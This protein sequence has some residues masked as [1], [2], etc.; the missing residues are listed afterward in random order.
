MPSG[1]EC[2]LHEVE[3]R[4]SR[5]RLHWIQISL[6]LRPV[7]INRRALSPVVRWLQSNPATRF[8][9]RE[10]ILQGSYNSSEPN[11]ILIGYSKLFMTTLLFECS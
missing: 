5:K 11:H 1:A 4:L 2:R 8:L 3:R 10:L 9:A 7:V 6:S